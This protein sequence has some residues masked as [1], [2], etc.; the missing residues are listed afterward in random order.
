MPALDRPLLRTA[1]PVAAVRPWGLRVAVGAGTA[2][3]VLGLGS[4]SLWQL[5]G[6]G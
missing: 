1:A 4:A 2:S 3:V 5:F 6:S